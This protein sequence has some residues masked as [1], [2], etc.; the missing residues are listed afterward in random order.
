LPC[1]G[2]TWAR[3]LETPLCEEVR[4]VEREDVFY[5]TLS[6]EASA[7]MQSTRPEGPRDV[8]LARFVL[9][10]DEVDLGEGWTSRR[11]TGRGE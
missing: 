9:V 11:E 5:W 3:S 1:L 7:V 8:D 4:H 2:P 6:L 10:F